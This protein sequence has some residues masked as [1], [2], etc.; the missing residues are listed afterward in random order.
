[1]ILIGPRGESVN[2]GECRP[3]TADRPVQ[4]CR[5]AGT[6]HFKGQRAQRDGLARRRLPSQDDRFWQRQLA[7]G[8]LHPLEQNV[9]EVPAQVIPARNRLPGR[10]PLAGS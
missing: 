7:K 3:V 5:L 6:R 8:G 1:M 4:H 9:L 10:M 2:V